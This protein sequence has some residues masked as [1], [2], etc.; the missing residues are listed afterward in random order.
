MEIT[1]D[2]NKTLE[3]TVE[4]SVSKLFN[5]FGNSLRKTKYDDLKELEQEIIEALMKQV[6]F[7]T[8]A[9]TKEILFYENG[10]YKI[11]GKD[12]IAIEAERICPEI[13]SHRIREI[14][15]HIRRRTTRD[16][17]LFDTTQDIVN[18]KNC[19]FDLN[20][21]KPIPHTPEHLSIIQFDVDYNPQATCP[22]L[23]K[24][25]KST[26]QGNDGKVALALMSCPLEGKNEFQIAGL[27]VG[28][29]NNGKGVFQNLNI[30]LFG[31]ENTA[32]VSLHDL[33]N[34][35]H[36]TADLYG[37]C[38]NVCGD[39][40]VT[41]LKD[42][43]TIKKI[44]G[45]DPIRAHK[46]FGQPFNFIP[47]LINLFSTNKLPETPDKSIGFF[48]RWIIIPFLNNF[49]G[50]EDRTLL[51]KLTTD[52]ELSGYL[53]LLLNSI[54]WRRK[55]GKF[56]GLESIE[57]REE[58]YNKMQDSVSYFL[59]ECTEE[60]NG[61]FVPKDELFSRCEQYCQH[62]NLPVESKESFGRK[63]TQLRHQSSKRTINGKRTYCWNNISLV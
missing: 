19:L 6:H 59:K 4:E 52:E 31:K 36:S 61:V 7:L 49:E 9:D 3:L 12:K 15:N 39:L 21:F 27:L 33:E 22:N 14:Q 45:G 47:K 18:L 13:S 55:T 57:H 46:K 62:N 30:G 20:E 26:L 43:S 5:K 35:P 41:P 10:V 32:N 37:K 60:K 40:P 24:F 23:L 53:N 44:T 51:T 42:T 28:N 16:R 11:G 48:R 2:N 29:G 50:R 38:L 17:E 63:L 34:D 56:P 25:I 58:M 54:K 1:Q 8:L